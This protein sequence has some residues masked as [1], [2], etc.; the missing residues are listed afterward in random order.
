MLGI[1]DAL[2][3]DPRVFVYG[4]DVGG[5][6]RQRVPAAAPA[7]EGVRRSHHQLAARRRRG[8]RRLRR[9][10]TGGPAADR[11]DPVQRF[12]R[13]RI[14]SAR[15]QRG[16]D[17]LPL[18]RRRADGRPDAVRRAAARRPVSLAEHRAVV[19]S[20]RGTEDRGSLDAARRARADGIG[21]GRSRSGALLRA[22]RA[23][24]RS[25]HQ[26]GCSDAAPPRRSRS[27]ARRCGAAAAI[28]RSSRTARSSTSACAWPRQLAADGI[29]AS[30]LDLRTLSPLDRRG[31]ARAGAPLPPRADH[32]RGL[33]HRR[34]RREPRGDHSGR[35]VRVARCAGPDRRRA[36]HAGPV[37]A[38]ARSVLPAERRANRA[39]RTAPA[40]SPDGGL[41]FGIRDSGFA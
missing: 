21:R 34:H 7:A 35:S 30:V 25:A 19:L 31:A 6:I 40:Q 3:G 15:Q 28:S 32:P 17:P 26:A 5:A 23:L 18:G 36:R 39:R 1:G 10:G 9:R 2:R 14:Q 33:A 22:H 4:E 41:G 27:A 16:E 24:P 8:A 20:H 11:R 12:R 37:L 29:E 13:N 38:A